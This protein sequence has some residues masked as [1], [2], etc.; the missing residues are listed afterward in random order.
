MIKMKEYN[1]LEGIIVSGMKTAFK[2]AKTIHKNGQEVM[3]L[4]REPTL[5]ELYFIDM[6]YLEKNLK[7]NRYARPVHPDE[8][9]GYEDIN[10]LKDYITVVSR[11]NPWYICKTPECI[12]DNMSS[13]SIAE[14]IW[15]FKE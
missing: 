7:I 8:A 2:D 5:A 13:R 9:E 11:S 4:G 6:T 3:Y 1:T 15:N 10:E 12:K 14:G